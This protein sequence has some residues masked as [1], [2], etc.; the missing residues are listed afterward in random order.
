MIVFSRRLTASELC[1]A[2]T[3]NNNKREAERR[4]AHCPTYVRVK[5][6]CAWLESRAPPFGAHAAAL[7]TG[8]YPDGSALEPGFPRPLAQGV[9]GERTFCPRRPTTKA[10][11]TAVKHAPCRPV[12][13]PVD[14]GSEAARVRIGNSARGD[15]TSLRS[16]GMPS[17]TAPFTERG[18][19][20]LLKRGRIVKEKVT[21][22]TT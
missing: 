3:T 18:A 2:T 17:G 7:A 1:H 11:K 19:I 21:S 8:C 10:T 14:R 5:R 22:P 4:K 13:V 15:R 6:G 16:Y 9:A 12:L 20:L